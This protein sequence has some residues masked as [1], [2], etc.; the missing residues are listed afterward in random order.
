MEEYDSLEEACSKAEKYENKYIT[1]I[2]MEK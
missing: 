2:S 1:G